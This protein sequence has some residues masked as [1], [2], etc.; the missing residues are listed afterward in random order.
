MPR[1]VSLYG[2]LRDVGRDGR[3]ELA[4]EPLEDDR[5]V[6]LAHRPEHLLAGRGPLQ[7]DG[8]VL[9]QQAGSAGPILSR[10]CFE[11]GS[12]ATTSDGAGNS[13]GDKRSGF[14]FAPQRVAGL[15][16]GQLGD[17]PDLAGL[18]LADRLLFLAVE[19]QQLADPLV[20]VAGGVPDV[21]L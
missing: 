3:A 2:H 14:S 4:L 5:G 17:R 19:Q 11:T 8:R 13:S 15:G 16:H 12:I 7:P 20:L 10:S 18:Q 6:R 1:I 21:R 9:L